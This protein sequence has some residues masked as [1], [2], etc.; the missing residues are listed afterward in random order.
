MKLAPL[1]PKLREA[2]REIKIGEIT[3]ILGFKKINNF[4]QD[5]LLKNSP[6][7]ND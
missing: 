6:L 7:W 2:A 1:L 3:Q 4:T 5:N